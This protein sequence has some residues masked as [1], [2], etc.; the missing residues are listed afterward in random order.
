MRPGRFVCIRH[1]GKK[2]H[3]RI[4]SQQTHTHFRT[5]KTESK[6]NRRIRYDMM[7]RPHITYSHLVIVLNGSA[8]RR[9]LRVRVCWNIVESFKVYKNTRKKWIRAV[10]GISTKFKYRRVLIPPA[11]MHPNMVDYLSMNCIFFLRIPNWDISM[12]KLGC[13]FLLASSSNNFRM[14]GIGSVYFKLFIVTHQIPNKRT[15]LPNVKVSLPTNW[16]WSIY[17]P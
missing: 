11:W 2:I 14:E 12:R 1:F 5:D 10:S 8:S 7:H 13:A 16:A 17:M 15:M 6:R 4:H 9:C 3:K